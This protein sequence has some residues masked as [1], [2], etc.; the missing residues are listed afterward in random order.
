APSAARG[1]L[2]P[3]WSGTT[4]AGRRGRG[5][6][7]ADGP[8]RT[9]RGSTKGGLTADSGVADSHVSR[10][11]SVTAARSPKIAVEP[12]RIG[13]PASIRASSQAIQSARQPGLDLE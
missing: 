1:R 10:H 3:G 11:H 9:L 12:A 7:T 4:H 2:R 8:G 13:S 5:A 6:V